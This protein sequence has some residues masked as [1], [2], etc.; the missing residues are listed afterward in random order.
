MGRMLRAMTNAGISFEKSPSGTKPREQSANGK[1]KNKFA[2]AA[3]TKNKANR[4]AERSL[5]NVPEKNAVSDSDD[6]NQPEYGGNIGMMAIVAKPKKHVSPRLI[7]A[8]M[9]G[10]TCS[11]SEFR[12]I[13]SVMR[14]WTEYRAMMRSMTRCRL[15]RVC[16]KIY[17]ENKMSKRPWSSEM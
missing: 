2:G 8:M 6:D 9:V 4:I 7:N 16:S 10:I 5:V 14:S 13:S 1:Q 3:K 15:T 17:S 12:R 11:N